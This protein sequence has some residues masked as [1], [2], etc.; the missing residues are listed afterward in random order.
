MDNARLD[1]ARRHAVV[2]TPERGEGPRRV[3]VEPRTDHQIAIIVPC[4]DEEVAIGQVVEDLRTAMPSATVYVYDNNSTDR[5]VEVARAAG[6]VVRHEARRGKGNVVRRAL[7]DIDADIYVL[8]DGD[9]TYDA[10]AVP[11]LVSTLIDGPYDQVVGVRRPD[12]DGAFR[13]GHEAGNRFFNRVVG[14]IFR[15]PVG[16]MLSGYRVFSRRFVR[17]F[18]AASK[19]F[20]IETELTIHA[21]NNRMPQCEVPV[22]F[23]DRGEGSESKLNTYRDGLRILGMIGRL[24]HH[25]RPFPVWILSAALFVLGS[26]L[27]GLPVVAE[28]VRTGAVDRLPTAVLSATLMVLALVAVTI[29]FV[30]DGLRKL[31]QEQTRIAYLQ[32]PTP[33]D[34]FTDGL[35]PA[36][37]VSIVGRARSEG[38]SDISSRQDQISA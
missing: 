28:Y 20:E 8:I 35:A 21:I 38:D 34:R 16:D 6:A 29:A 27:T 12:A 23:K 22:G 14:S 33:I 37:L 13:A 18:P 2:R 25:E 4:F 17:S 31:R 11:M 36:E 24:L 1:H 30:L 26:L 3:A 10:T 32:Q 9:D 19:A 7:A 5:T 15:Q